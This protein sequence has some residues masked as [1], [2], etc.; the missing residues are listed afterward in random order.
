MRGRDAELN[1][2]LAAYSDDPLLPRLAAMEKSQ[3]V[4]PL[5]LLHDSYRTPSIAANFACARDVG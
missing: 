5:A 1:F 2:G 3:M 4:R